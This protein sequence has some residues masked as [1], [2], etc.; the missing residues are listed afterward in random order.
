MKKARMF[1][2]VVAGLGIMAGSVGA[3]PLGKGQCRG[4]Q[5]ETVVI[6]D[7]YKEAV[8]GILNA[9]AEKQEA[10]ASIDAAIVQ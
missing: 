3:K 9:I 7:P 8:D 5:A 10:L 1:F 2:C 4:M 6:A